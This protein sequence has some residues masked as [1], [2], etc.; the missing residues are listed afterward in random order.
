MIAE[1]NDIL[2]QAVLDK[3]ALRV[4]AQFGSSTTHN[5]KALQW[6]ES[7]GPE[8]LWVHLPEEGELTVARFGTALPAVDISFAVNQTR[9]AFES[10]VLSR[11]RRFWVNDSVMFDALLIAAPA[12]V[13]KLDER[14]HP[15]L[16]VSQGSGVS[17]QLIRLDKPKADAGL[18]AAKA[19]IPVDGTLN[20]LSLVGAGFMCTPDRALLTAQR[21]ERLACVVDFRGA[22][23]V[24]ACSLARVTS[25]STRAMRVGVDFAAHEN[26]KAMTGK[27]AE[28]ANVVA[29]LERQESLRRR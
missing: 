1:I 20:D 28:L 11:N 25:V 3:I 12:A 19:L 18:S 15:R 16:P 9:Y 27:L 21:G 4:T 17:A 8:G 22:K 29:E 6:S 13:R 10:K 14:R 2:K 23:L 5:A 24:L 26:E 7:P